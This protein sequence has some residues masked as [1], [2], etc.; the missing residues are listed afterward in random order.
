M[1]LTVPVYQRWPRAAPIPRSSVQL[2]RYRSAAVTGL[3]VAPYELYSPAGHDT[4]PTQ[5]NLLC[6]TKPCGRIAACTPPAQLEARA[7]TARSLSQ[8]A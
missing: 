1:G 4:R 8:R 7:P 5:H 3:R 6:H 2:P